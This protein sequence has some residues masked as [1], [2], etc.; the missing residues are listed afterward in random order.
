M[1]VKLKEKLTIE[2]VGKMNI[3]SLYRYYYPGAGNDEIDFWFWECT[4]FPF[5][6]RK[7]I[8]ML[9]A[10]YVHDMNNLYPQTKSYENEKIQ[11]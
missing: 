8:E 7:A 5:D 10:K 6:V 11:S 1:T 2:Q 4:P 3:I 9:Y